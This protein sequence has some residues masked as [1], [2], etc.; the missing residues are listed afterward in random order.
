MTLLISMAFLS[1]CVTAKYGSFINDDADEIAAIQSNQKK[2]ADDL[3][4]KLKEHYPPASTRL[5]IKHSISDKDFYGTYMIEALRAVGY[6]VEEHNKNATAPVTDSLTL[7]YILDQPKEDD[8]Y[9][10]YRLTVFVSGAPMSRMYEVAK[11]GIAYPI[12]YWVR[13]VNI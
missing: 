5:S 8:E 4:I 9:L 6:G 1:G 3:I 10:I 11:D 13:R 12:G 7:S 2:I